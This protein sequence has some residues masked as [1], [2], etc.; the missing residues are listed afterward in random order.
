MFGIVYDDALY[1]KVNDDNRA[2]YEA[3]GSEPFTPREGQTLTSYY[4]VPPD[5]VDSPDLVDWADGAIAA[6]GDS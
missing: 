6:A 1:M 3:A 5:V 4:E 2:D